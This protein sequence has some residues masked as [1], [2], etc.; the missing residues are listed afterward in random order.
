MRFFLGHLLI[1]LAFSHD[2]SPVPVDPFFFLDH[3]ADSAVAPVV[4]V[5]VPLAVSSLVSAVPVVVIFIP[6][7]ISL[8]ISAVL[9]SAVFV[10]LAASPLVPAVLFSAAQIALPVSFSSHHLS[11]LNT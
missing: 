11:F 1:V 8:L 7:A 9:V 5:F 10:P 3:V 6:L 4:A 2:F